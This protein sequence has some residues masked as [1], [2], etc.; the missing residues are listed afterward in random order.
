MDSF[1]IKEIMDTSYSEI[2]EDLISADEKRSEEVKMIF[3]D[4]ETWLDNFG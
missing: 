4:M 1:D 2:I 3:M